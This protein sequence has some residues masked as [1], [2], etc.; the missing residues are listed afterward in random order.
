MG[1]CGYTTLR[2]YSG[3]NKTL[4]IVLTQNRD[5]V[6]GDLNKFTFGAL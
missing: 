5:K 6:R 2:D 3:K 4:S 1:I